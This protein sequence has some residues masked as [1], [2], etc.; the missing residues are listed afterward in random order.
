[1]QGVEPLSGSRAILLRHNRA[2]AGGAVYVECSDMGSICTETFSKDNTIGA[3][4]QL[5]KV[6]FAGNAASFYGNAVALK[7]VSMAWHEQG[8]TS[9]IEL[10][11]GE[12]PLSLAVK[13]FDSQGNL[14]K[15]SEDIIE[16]LICPVSAV[17]CTVS[18]ASIPAIN[19]GFNPL[20]GLSS[21][22]A[23][24]ECNTVSKMEMVTEMSFQIR[25]IG[26]EYIPRVSGRILCKMCKTGQRLI[27][28]D[29]RGTWSCEECGPG[30]YNVNPFTGECFPCPLTAM[31]V[32]GVPI[33]QAATVKG[34]IELSGLPKDGGKEATRKV[35]DT[36]KCL[37]Q[38]D[39]P[40]PSVIRDPISISV[41]DCVSAS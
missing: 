8:N 20:T 38:P 17:E 37:P 12:Q 21:I 28:H 32:H 24:V 13:L 27:T 34:E 35:T 5:P 22:E 25:V 33:F 26:A 9:I 40:P 14:V 30:T 23:A 29:S 6:E 3:L 10:V 31:C 16:V 4:P 15:G 41:F 1:M 18:S 39:I 11:P 36:N 7:A 2:R 19:Q